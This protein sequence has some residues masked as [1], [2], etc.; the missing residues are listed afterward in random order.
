MTP[1]AGFAVLCGYTALAFGLAVFMLQRE[2]MRQ[3]ISRL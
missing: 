1:W 3:V 2:H